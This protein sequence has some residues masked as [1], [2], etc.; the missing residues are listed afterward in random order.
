MKK[1]KVL[2]VVGT[3]PEIIRLS[4]CLNSFDENFDHILV[5][6]NQ[7]YDFELNKVFFTDMNLKN[8]KYSIQNK[9][10]KMFEILGNSFVEIEKIIQKERPDAFVVLGDTNSAITSYVAKRNKL[11]IIHIEAGNRCFDENVPEEINRKIVD[12]ISDLNVVYSDFAEK[13]LIREGISNNKIINLGS[14]LYEV[15]NHYKKKINSYKILKKY[16]LKNKNYIL[17]SFHRE[18]NVQNKKKLNEF[19]DIINYLA[20]KYKIPVLVSTHPRLKKVLSS[21][22]KRTNKFIKFHKPFSFT[23]YLSL[24][25]SSKLVISD[26]GS[27]PEETSILNLKS[28]ILRDT[29]ERQE[30]LSKSACVISPVK[31]ENFKKIL[32]VELKTSTKINKRLLEYENQ[33]FSNHLSRIIVSKIEFIN[34]YIW[35]KIENL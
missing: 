25:L 30:I 14:P 26:S 2:T 20:V 17:V 9:N 6:T 3:R 32:E 22:K 29:F 24:Q 15:I 27:I 31:L 12:H 8:P 1:Y 10:N 19:L 7:N 23:E 34:K 16:N 11:P 4:R 13:N 18:E 21:S 28:I 5:H 33:S 35:N